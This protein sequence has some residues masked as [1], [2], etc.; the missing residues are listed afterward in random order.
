RGGAAGRRRP[1]APRDR[2][3]PRAPRRSARGDRRGPRRAPG[4]RRRGL[5]PQPRAGDRRRRGDRDRSA[6]H[7]GPQGAGAHVPA[8]CR[9]PGRVGRRSALVG[10][11]ASRCTGRGE[12]R[13]E[14]LA[15]GG[16]VEGRVVEMETGEGKS[17][18]ATLPACT[19]ALAGYPVH[20]V[21]VNDYLAER[22]ATEMGPLYRFLGLSV[23]VVVQGMPKAARR[24]AYA[25]SV[26]YCTNK[27]LAFDYLRDR[28]ALARRSSRLHLALE[29]LRG[30]AA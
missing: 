28:V 9:A 8:R 21:T 23:G 29:R 24:E 20:V 11:A 3:C 16:L 30:D 17:F 4:P 7:Q 5:S 25:R 13:L 6:R 1:G 12:C 10:G 14:V 19:A 27:E 2:P 22:G 15:G 18:A 26:T